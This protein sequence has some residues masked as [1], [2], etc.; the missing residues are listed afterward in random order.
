MLS[1]TKKLSIAGALC[2][3]ALSAIGVNAIV[4]ATAPIAGDL[5]DEV[6]SDDIG[7]GLPFGSHR[8]LANENDA[9]SPVMGV[10]ALAGQDGKKSLRFVAALDGYEGLESASFA[11]TVTSKDGTVIKDEKA[12][13]VT[14]VYTSVKDA[15]TIHWLSDLHDS[16]QYFMVYTLRNIPQTDWFD[17]VDVSLTATPIDGDA[18]S[19]NQAANVYGI[20]GEGSEGVDFA[21]TDAEKTAGTWHVVKSDGGISKAVVPERHLSI[22]GDIATDLGPVVC[23][24]DPT[25]YNGGFEDCSYLSEV[26][27]PDTI[28]EFNKY[29]FS[30]C[31]KLTALTFPRDLTAI[32]SSALNDMS[33]LATLTYDA[34]A[35]SAINDTF[36]S[37]DIDLVRVSQGVVSLPEARIIDVSRVVKK[38][39]YGGT[40]SAWATLIGDKQNGLDIDNV[41]CSDT[42][43]V[44]VTY[45]IGAGSLAIDGE[46]VSGDYVVSAIKGH[47]AAEIGKPILADKY[48]TGWF[49]EATGGTLY[50]FATALTA[51]L[52][53]YAQ[54]ADFPNGCSL[55]KPFD[56]SAASY[57]GT[58]TTVTGMPDFFI[59][60]TAPAADIYYFAINEVTI[61]ADISDTTA[62]SYLQTKFYDAAKTEVAPVSFGIEK[63]DP[64]QTYSSS[65]P[66]IY[67]LNMEQGQ[68]Y[69]VSLN[70]YVNSYSPEKKAFGD[71]DIAIWTSANDSVA[72]AAP[73]TDFG[74][75]QEVVFDGRYSNS[76]YQDLMYSY[77]PATDKQVSFT[78]ESIGNMYFSFELYDTA[79][80]S[81]EIAHCSG[82]SKAI[83]LLSLEAGHTYIVLAS[84]N[85]PSSETEKVY[86]SF[87][88]PAQGSVGSNPLT[89]A[90]GADAITVSN[91]GVQYSFYKVTVAS[92]GAYRFLLGG[93]SSSY[94]KQIYLLS[95]DGATAIANK[96]EVGE[97]DGSGW[98]DPTYTYGT[99][100]ELDS[101]LAAGDYLVKVGYSSNSSTSAFAL[102]CLVA[103]PGEILES[104][105]AYD[106]ADGM[107]DLSATVNGTYYAFVPTVSATSTLAFAYGEGETVSISLLDQDGKTLQTSSGDAFHYDFVEGA[108]Y[109]LLLKDDA[110][111][112][113][114][115]T[116]S[117]YSAPL[118][119]KAFLGEYM[120]C[121]NGSS[122]YKMSLVADG[123][124]WESGTAISNLTIAS[125]ANG[126]SLLTG[127]GITITT[128]ST[129]AWV[130][131]GSDNYLMSKD[132]GNYSSDAISGQQ[133]KT[134]GADNVSG[135]II[136]SV[137]KTSD[138]SRKYAVMKDGT[139]YLGAVVS[140]TSGDSIE[141]SE[142]AFS[143]ADA[144]GNPIGSYSYDGSN[145]VAA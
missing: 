15:D 55:D 65:D 97:E 114:S 141:G 129:D 80:L 134:A 123:Y 27:L 99:S 51:D 32:D 136:Q 107:A 37:R 2:A 22:E 49:T 4:S 117:V 21:Q 26:V 23:V 48:C 24:G 33:A 87:A 40:S 54:Y 93:G 140:F 144:S 127:E 5:T 17:R 135:V 110:G 126:I 45:H 103:A 43:M 133:V 106:F 64:I 138:G 59:K 145:L 130:T 44:T 109:Y 67:G 108:T 104:A 119:G 101:K 16:Y 142:S 78:G 30:H 6:V 42:E 102:Q 89:L 31:S 111:N 71:M 113:I 58:V 35:L 8:L 75:K 96:T 120:G 14:T 52:D 82:V 9:L 118:S 19:A 68:V 86:F 112:A 132:C 53:L 41:F 10:Q 76:N 39:E 74:A 83:S 105:L 98:G 1:K 36:D 3:L 7:T 47:Q 128:D 69:Y 121:R 77:T 20:V 90:V 56:I 29:C 131:K 88:E 139:I 81:S 50:D 85:G 61:N 100:F 72:T 46:S 137:V 73:Y 18:L 95:A 115:V 91:L 70:A 122:Y 143:I 94:A 60:F 38:I 12:F 116:K 84:S 13:A 11:R 66:W 34:K 79:D 28:Q 92:E 57:S 125:E 124:T 63:D 25:S 62:I